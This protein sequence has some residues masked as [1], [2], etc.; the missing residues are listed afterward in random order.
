MS[1]G[2]ISIEVV[3][4]KILLIRGRKFK[5]TNCDLKC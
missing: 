2:K 1:K 5:V 4:A 3:A